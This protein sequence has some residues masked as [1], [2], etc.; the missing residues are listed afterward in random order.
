MSKPLAA[1]L[2]AVSSGRVQT[3][4]LGRGIGYT[5]SP[6][7]HKA[8]GRALGLSV[9]YHVLDGREL[10]LGP[11]D[12]PAL[13]AT[14]QRRGYAGLNVTY[15]YKQAVIAALDELDPL[16]VELEAVNTVVFGADAQM[17]GHNT[18]ASGFGAG[19]DEGL[20]GADLAFVV[21][22]GAGGA[23]AATA[24]ALLDRGTQRLGL[25]DPDSERRRELVGRLRRGF[26]A[27]R[28][29]EIATDGLAEAVATCSGIVNASP[30]GSPNAPGNPI[31]PEALRRTHWVA[32]IVYAPLE[33]QLLAAARATGART[34]D[35]GR[36]LVHQAACSFQ[37]FHGV[38][39]DVMR[40]R[41]HF[42]TLTAGAAA[43]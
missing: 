7:L 13:L 19:L 6:S 29:E 37:L 10:D 28:I 4:I 11:E 27:A 40:M 12:L 21:Q 34:L 31:P 15:P 3:G 8:E 42:L 14:L 39:A 24:R 5:L 33:T 17:T 38:A 20:A 23:G 22:T 1:R 25:A 9:D 32:D 26:P 41:T 18:D 30:V 43:C 35:G 16:A 2:P 36:M